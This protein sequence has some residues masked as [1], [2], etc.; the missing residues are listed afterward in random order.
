M[1]RKKRNPEIFA[2]D[3]DVPAWV[4]E[5]APARTTPY[6]EQELDDLVEST[7]ESIRD[8]AAWNDLVE[9]VGEDDA[10]DQLRARLILRDE[11]ANVQSRH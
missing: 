6:T 8:T 7:L 3:E 9:R 4:D 5:D 11:R 2:F 1:R 10:R